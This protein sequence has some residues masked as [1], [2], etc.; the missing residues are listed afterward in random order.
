MLKK[1]GKLSKHILP[2]LSTDLKT[3]A[4]RE[5]KDDLFSLSSF[6]VFQG[7]RDQRVELLVLLL[8]FILKRSF[9]AV[10]FY[11]IA[12]RAWG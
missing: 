8:A 3:D 10:S 2:P 5:F 11:V 4:V 6:S 9:C 1:L 12:E 7:E